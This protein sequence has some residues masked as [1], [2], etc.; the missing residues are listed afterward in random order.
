MVGLA[1][2]TERGSKPGAASGVIQAECT[3]I[4]DGVVELAALE[5]VEED[6][7]Q[8]AGDVADRNHACRA[9]AGAASTTE[10]GSAMQLV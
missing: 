2:T 4:S 7:N 3:S 6:R 9:L 10:T 8:L 1:A 5:T